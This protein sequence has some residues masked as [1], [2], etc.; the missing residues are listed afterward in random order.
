MP[1]F[2]RGRL[3]F[4]NLIQIILFI[5]VIQKEKQKDRMDVFDCLLLNFAE[6]MLDV[7]EDTF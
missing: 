3:R 2:N 4:Y 1:F 6:K 5:F 7:M